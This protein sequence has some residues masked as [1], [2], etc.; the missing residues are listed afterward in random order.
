M[1]RSFSVLALALLLVGV[2]AVDEASD[3]DV[4]CELS[5]LRESQQLEEQH[6]DRILATSLV[7]QSD[8]EEFEFPRF[9]APID[10]RTFNKIRGSI[11][12]PATRL[13]RDGEPD[14]VVA[15][16]GDKDTDTE[17]RECPVAVCNAAQQKKCQAD[18]KDAV[19][20]F[21]SK[22]CCPAG[23]TCLTSNPPT[24]VKEDPLSAS[25]CAEGQCA[26]D[27]KCPHKG[28]ETCCP[29]GNSCCPEGYECTA[30]NPPRCLR[31]TNPKK[32]AYRTEAFLD[33]ARDR[34]LKE[35][36]KREAEFEKRL[37]DK[38]ESAKINKKIEL[39]KERLPKDNP[40]ANG[41]PN[42]SS[43][44]GAAS[45]VKGSKSTH[46]S[47]KLLG[48]DG[49]PKPVF[50]RLRISKDYCLAAKNHEVKEGALITLFKCDGSGSQTWKFHSDKTVRPAGND[51]LCLTTGV[52]GMKD[53]SKVTLQKCDSTKKPAGQRWKYS[54]KEY[55][56]LSEEDSQFV[57]TLNGGVVENNG[58][59]FMFKQED[60]NPSQQFTVAEIAWKFDIPP[61]VHIQSSTKKELC[62][63]VSSA[64]AKNG[65]ALTLQK[66]GAKEATQLFRFYPDGTVRFARNPRYCL[67]LKNGDLN[68]G[69][70]IQLFICNPKS[71][72]QKF[73]YTLKDKLILFAAKPSFGLSVWQNN[74]AVGGEIRLAQAAPGQQAQMFERPSVESNN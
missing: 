73:V 29:G 30:D 45:P 44:G 11:S 18:D 60:P 4:T 72:N 16:L 36:M 48:K 67:D 9:A 59:V 23:H 35:R 7:E 20:C 64:D 50:I 39:E 70:N 5:R 38:I 37:K 27:W 58:V 52:G 66:C 24:C 22:T 53:G 34:K 74:L 63:G 10:H 6:P 14:R 71:Q 68:V 12:Q 26:G 46:I 3:C 21:T 51:Q 1:G 61:V 49:H 56:L 42:E 15:M 2:C 13:V 55:S 43:V 32:L 54:D 33:I 19:C 69:A 65:L 57:L 25:R 28:V 62:A 31:I 40:K 17:F 8:Q 41:P 47:A